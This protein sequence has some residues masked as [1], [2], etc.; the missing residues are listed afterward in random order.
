M[1]MLENGGGMGGGIP[2]GIP[3]PMQSMGGMMGGPDM[4]SFGISNQPQMGMM[5]NGMGAPMPMM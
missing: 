5:P 2:G 4:S 1:L 3:M